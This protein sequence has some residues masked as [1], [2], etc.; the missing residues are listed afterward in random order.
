MN[1]YEYKIVETVHLLYETELNKYGSQ[2]WELTAVAISFKYNYY[3]F[4]RIKL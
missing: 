1:K 3:Y 4:K 2:G